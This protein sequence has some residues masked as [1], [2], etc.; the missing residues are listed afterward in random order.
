MINYTPPAVEGSNIT[1][2]CSESND[3]IRKNLTTNNRTSICIDGQWEP[4]LVQL[5]SA[6]CGGTMANNIIIIVL[7]LL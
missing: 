7:W 6:E 4:N 5:I 2:E 1:I 3:A